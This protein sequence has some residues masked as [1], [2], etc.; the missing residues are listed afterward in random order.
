MANNTAEALFLQE[1]G[2]NIYVYYDE[3]MINGNK[4]SL[5]DALN[6]IKNEENKKILTS[7]FGFGENDETSYLVNNNFFF[8]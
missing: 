5:L 1:N 6:I 3:I 8:L 7:Y 2:S 4:V